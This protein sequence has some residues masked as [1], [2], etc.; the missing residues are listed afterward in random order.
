MAKDTSFRDYILEQLTSIGMVRTRSMFGGFGLYSHDLCF[1]LLPS[2][3]QL[4][5]KVDANNIADY[6]AA[7]MKPFSPNAKQTLK[8]FYEVPIGVIEDSDELVAWA[9]KAI[10]AQVGRS[11]SKS[12]KPASVGRKPQAR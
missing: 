6:E 3:G 7:G 1:G 2:T 8:S 5:F 12:S 9:R 10:A 11:D 4:Y